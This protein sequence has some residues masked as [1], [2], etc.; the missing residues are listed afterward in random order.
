VK[1]EQFDAILYDLDEPTPCAGAHA[2]FEGADNSIVLRWAAKQK[3]RACPVALAC[4][5]T[6]MAGREIG[7][8]GGMY[9]SDG[10]SWK[11]IVPV[12]QRWLRGK[13]LAAIREHKGRAAV[14]A[15][16]D[17]LPGLSDFL[18]SGSPA[19]P[20]AKNY[21]RFRD[22]CIIRKDIH[23]KL[24]DGTSGSVRRYVMTTVMMVD[25]ESAWAGPV[26][27]C[28]SHGCIAPWH[29]QWQEV[30]TNK[31]AFRMIAYAVHL[32]V[33]NPAKDKVTAVISGADSGMSNQFLVALSLI[34]PRIGVS[35][36]DASLPIVAH[37]A[38]EKKLATNSPVKRALLDIAVTA[39][40]FGVETISQL[41]DI[42]AR[43]A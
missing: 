9:S 21:H 25:G 24:P 17:Y 8:W 29:I 11:G 1:R 16:E 30:G 35:I 39:E 27:T 31:M 20:S 26:T 22:Q 28:S 14:T 19:D 40:H 6:G 13:L 5:K 7:V 18:Y 12:Q 4:L 10:N 34:L 42:G 41:A 36:P 37:W 15:A 2:L 33:Q 32:A 38:M 23:H 43:E 3:C